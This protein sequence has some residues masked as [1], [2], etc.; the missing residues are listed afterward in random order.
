MPPVAVVELGVA[1]AVVVSVVVLR[2]GAPPSEGV[3]VT[4]T[5]MTCVEAEGVAVTVVDA[6]VVWVMT[7]T[8]LWTPG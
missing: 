7:E 3:T 2:T 8:V 1:L 6:M 4:I 5:V